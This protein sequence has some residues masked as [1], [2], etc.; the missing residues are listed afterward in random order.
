[1]Q[2]VSEFFIFTQE[3]LNEQLYLLLIYLLLLLF[4]FCCLIS[5][6]T[7]LYLF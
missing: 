4:F 2:S 3:N 1:M 7:P 6:I 5:L